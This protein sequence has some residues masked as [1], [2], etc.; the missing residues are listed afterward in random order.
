MA[1]MGRVYCMDDVERSPIEVTRVERHE[2]ARSRIERCERGITVGE[3]K[4]VC[5]LER[6]RSAVTDEESCWKKTSTCNSDA[7]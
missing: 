7:L 3:G 1:G 2:V 6:A 5:E 4:R